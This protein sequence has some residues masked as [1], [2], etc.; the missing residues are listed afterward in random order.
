VSEW[1]GKELAGEEESL[2]SFVCNILLWQFVIAI[3]GR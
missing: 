3:G 1:V 2:V